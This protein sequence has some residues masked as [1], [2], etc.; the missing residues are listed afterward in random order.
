MNRV[1]RYHR[2]HARL[3]LAVAIVFTLAMA[4]FDAAVAYAWWLS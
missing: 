1:Q 2:N 4:A 3:S